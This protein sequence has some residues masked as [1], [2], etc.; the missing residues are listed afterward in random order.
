M[1]EQFIYIATAF[2]ATLSSLAYAA[3]K[4]TSQA[5]TGQS[6]PQLPSQSSQQPQASQSSTPQAPTIQMVQPVDCTQLTADQMTFSGQ[7]TDMNLKAAFCTQLTSDQREKVMAMTYQPDAA[8]NLLTADQAMQ[9]YMQ[10]NNMQAPSA[11]SART[12]PRR[13]G[14]GC[15]AQ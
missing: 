14:G 4:T 5:Q 3:P 11:P 10:T 15:P 1:R 9:K 7:F 2:V 8:G 6:A 13:S 12:I